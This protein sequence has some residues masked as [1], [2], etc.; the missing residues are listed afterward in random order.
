MMTTGSFRAVG[1]QQICTS[2]VREPLL[3]T[4]F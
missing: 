1:L 2:V 4:F 3:D